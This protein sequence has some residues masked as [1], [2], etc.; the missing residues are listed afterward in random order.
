MIIAGYY[1]GYI[2]GPRFGPGL[3]QRVAISTSSPPS[4]RWTV[5]SI[6]SRCIPRPD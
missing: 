3:I 5:A 6:Y 4:P 2:L 1:V